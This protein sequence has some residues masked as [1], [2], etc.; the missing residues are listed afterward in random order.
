MSYLRVMNRASAPGKTITA[1]ALTPSGCS[2]GTLWSPQFQSLDGE[3][4]SPCS[5]HLLILPSLIR[6]YSESYVYQCTE[7]IAKVHFRL[8]PS[9]W[10][11][12]SYEI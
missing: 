7:N 8:Y 1:L 12:G 2:A 10:I 4:Y 5:E 11:M 9:F 6:A 3:T